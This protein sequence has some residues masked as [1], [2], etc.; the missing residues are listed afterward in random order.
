MQTVN[1]NTARNNHSA[2]F[3]TP[4]DYPYIGDLRLSR[5]RFHPLPFVHLE[6]VGSLANLATPDN[7]NAPQSQNLM[8]PFVTL[9]SRPKRWLVQNN[10]SLRSVISTSAPRSAMEKASV[11][12]GSV[13]ESCFGA[14]SNHLFAGAPQKRTSSYGRVSSMTSIL[15]R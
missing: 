3:Q 10:T 4:W 1:A 2:S 15:K 14:T 7:S 12:V 6:H 13:K 11:H 5:A 9:R 8:L